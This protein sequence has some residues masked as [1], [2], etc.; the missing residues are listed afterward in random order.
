MARPTRTIEAQAASLGPAPPPAAA[1]PDLA[2]RE[3]HAESGKLPQAKVLNEQNLDE[4]LAQQA[5]APAKKSV[6]QGNQLETKAANAPPRGTYGGTA[7]SASASALPAAP[8]PNA[9]AQ[10][11]AAPQYADEAQG[12][13]ENQQKNAADMRNQLG[14]KAAN[15]KQS[16]EKPTDDAV[17]RWRQS[18]Q[19]AQTPE[20]R[21]AALKQLLVAAQAA[22]DDK[23]AKATQQALKAA[24]LQVVARKRAQG[25]QETPP[26]QRAKAAPG[27]APGEFKAQKSRN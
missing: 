21:I 18:A 19:D 26:A 3:L 15:D 6:A 23:T 12:K 27:Q 8:Q 14:E 11:N 24:Q 22:G 10:A 4:A 17:A 7:N 25:L 13:E 9:A 16:A 20:E 5:D 2:K 1:A